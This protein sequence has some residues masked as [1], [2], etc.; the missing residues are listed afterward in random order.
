MRRRVRAVVLV[1]QEDDGEEGVGAEKVGGVVALSVVDR[2][3]VSVGYTAATEGRRVRS[4]AVQREPHGLETLLA[5]AA[6]NAQVGQAREL[7]R[8]RLHRSE[9]RRRARAEREDRRLALAPRTRR[10]NEG[11]PTIGAGQVRRGDGDPHVGAPPQVGL[12]KAGDLGKIR[13]QARLLLR[14]RPG[15][16]DH[17]EQVELRPLGHLDGLH[18]RDGDHGVE[19]QH[20]VVVAGAEKQEQRPRFRAS[21]GGSPPG[22]RGEFA[23]ANGARQSRGSAH[24]GVQKSAPVSAEWSPANHWPPAAIGR[25]CAREK[26][27]ANDHLEGEVDA[28]PGDPVREPLCRAGSRL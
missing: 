16:V 4:V 2:A 22:V 1:G 18:P 19:G 27:C 26:K 9:R 20:R 13:R 23:G 8:D 11:A 5:V 25:T 7:R 21:H 28:Y 6:A 12:E 10:L 14:H 3:A 17:K 15:V 24:E